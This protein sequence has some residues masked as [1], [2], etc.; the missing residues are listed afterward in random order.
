MTAAAFGGR[1]MLSSLLADFVCLYL[2]GPQRRLYR[3]QT[4]AGGCATACGDRYRYGHWQVFSMLFVMVIPRIEFSLCVVFLN[5][6]C[7]RCADAE[8]QPGSPFQAGRAAIGG[9]CAVA[10]AA[11]NNINALQTP[12]ALYAIAGPFANSSAHDVG[13]CNRC[14]KAHRPLLCSWGLCVIVS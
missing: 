4:D 11:P 7:D 14:Q 13:C 6:T 9:R 2:P 1:G 10:A 5:A 8:P 12:H 3:Y